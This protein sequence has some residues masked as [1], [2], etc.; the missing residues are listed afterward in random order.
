VFIA[1]SLL[2]ILVWRRATYRL[3][4]ALQNVST[5]NVDDETK[6]WLSR[7][8]GAILAVALVIGVVPLAAYICVP[9]LGRGDGFACAFGLFLWAFIVQFGVMNVVSH[10]LLARR[11]DA[12]H[13][14]ERLTF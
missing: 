7:W 12:G 14:P 13:V 4:P 5:N 1:A 6:R 2:L 3:D 11:R 8:M 10:D 9:A